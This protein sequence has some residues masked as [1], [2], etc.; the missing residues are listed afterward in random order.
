[1]LAWAG[2]SRRRHARHPFPMVEPARGGFVGLQPPPTIQHDR[3]ILALRQPLVAATVVWRRMAA[4][5]A[6]SRRVFPVSA[7][8]L[9]D[10]GQKYAESAILHRKR[11]TIQGADPRRRGLIQIV[12]YQWA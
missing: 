12:A 5:K 4:E 8:F 9:A 6:F 3:Q 2:P 7:C 11:R 1:M 10:T